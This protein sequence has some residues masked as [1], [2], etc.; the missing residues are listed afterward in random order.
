MNGSEHKDNGMSN[1]PIIIK[2]KEEATM[3][4]AVYS[5]LVSQIIN[6]QVIADE[7]DFAVR[8]LRARMPEVAVSHSPTFP[9]GEEPRVVQCSDR[10]CDIVRGRGGREWWCETYKQWLVNDVAGYRGMYPSSEDAQAALRSLTHA[11]LTAPVGER[12]ES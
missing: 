10:K 4:I 7:A 2:S 8:E 5:A 11:Q 1:E 3:F 9:L 6:R 12:R